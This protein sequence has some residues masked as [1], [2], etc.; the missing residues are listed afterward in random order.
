MEENSLY[1]VQRKVFFW[2]LYQLLISNK[3]HYFPSEVF[4]VVQ[5]LG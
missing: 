3:P 4:N 5:L 1:N 2:G